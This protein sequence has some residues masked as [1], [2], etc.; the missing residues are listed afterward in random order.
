MIVSIEQDIEHDKETD[1]DKQ[2]KMW[3]DFY[4]PGDIQESDT[5]KTLP[6]FGDLL[7]IDNYQELKTN[8][9]DQIQK[10]KETINQF[11]IKKNNELKEK[12]SNGLITDETGLK[13][14]KA[15]IETKIKSQKEGFAAI[16]NNNIR[17]KIKNF[18]SDKLKKRGYYYQEKLNL[19]FNFDYYRKRMKQVYKPFLIYANEQ[20]NDQEGKSIKKVYVHLVGLGTGAWGILPKKQEEIIVRVVA[21][22][23]QSTSL[24]NI[25]HIDFSWFSDSNKYIQSGS[26][27]ISLNPDIEIFFSSNDPASKKKTIK[28]D[29]HEKLYT[30]NT[31]KTQLVAMYAW[32]SN[33]YPGNE[34]WIDHLSGSGDPAAACSSTI[35]IVHNPE[36]N[37]FKD[38]LQGKIKPKKF[39]RD[40]VVVECSLVNHDDSIGTE[41]VN[42][43]KILMKNEINDKTTGIIFINNLLKEDD[44]EKVWIKHSNDSNQIK[45]KLNYKYLH[46]GKLYA[47]RYHQ[48]EQLN[49]IIEAEKQNRKIREQNE[50]DRIEKIRKAEENRLYRARHQHQYDWRSREEEEER[51]E[52][53]RKADAEANAYWEAEANKWY[54]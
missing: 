43:A 34:Y 51:Q 30:L 46:E 5:K 22:I 14:R 28:Y 18:D 17:N 26:G 23:L 38:N 44:N 35:P 4:T 13:A 37:S 20:G 15:H 11:V 25:S 6:T 52:S 9:G 50:K 32:D 31:N 29:N 53:Y 19:Y 41:T 1:I 45:N 36:F 8:I 2:K 27:F 16:I 21:D 33:S 12:I 48:Y 10:N 49:K 3:Y 42:K 39:E 24:P 47:L 7:S 40:S 54:E